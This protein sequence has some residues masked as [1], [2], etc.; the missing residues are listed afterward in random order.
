MA[1][2]LLFCPVLL[3]FFVFNFLTSPVELIISLKFFYRQEAGI[4]DMGGVGSVP[5]RPHNFLLHYPSPHLQVD[6]D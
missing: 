6:S 4:E 3:L 1:T 2:L 5:G